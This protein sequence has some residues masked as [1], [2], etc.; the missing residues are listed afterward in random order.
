[1]STVNGQRS[2]PTRQQLIYSATL[3]APDKLELSSI[4][5]GKKNF[6]SGQLIF[7]NW[8]VGSVD[9]FF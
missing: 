8:S 4:R 5:P 6:G 7:D 9:V 3:H 1:M 2:F